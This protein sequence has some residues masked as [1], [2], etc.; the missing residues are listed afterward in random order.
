MWG[1][2]I[3]S[4]CVCVCVCVCVCAC[5]C[6]CA[7]ECA[8]VCR[9]VVVCTITEMNMDRD[10]LKGISCNVMHSIVFGHHIARDLAVRDV[11]R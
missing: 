2:H 6:A 11:P 1:Y 8:C 9:S 10:G 5:A 4:S 7:C 3:C